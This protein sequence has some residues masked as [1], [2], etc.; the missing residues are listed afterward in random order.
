M[1]DGKKI[2]AGCCIVGAVILCAGACNPWDESANAILV[3]EVYEVCPGDT[4]WDIAERYIT[5]NTGTRRSILEYKAGIEENNPWLIEHRGMIYPSDELK[6][7][8][9]VKGEDR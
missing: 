6:L 3:E 5:K 2:V 8:Y 9:W 4:I 7:T 1:V